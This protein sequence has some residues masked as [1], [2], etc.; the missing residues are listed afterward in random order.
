M[1]KSN[2]YLRFSDFYARLGRLRTRLVL[3]GDHETIRRITRHLLPRLPE[4]D[5]LYFTED[6]CFKWV[7]DNEH[8]IRYFI[9]QTDNANS[10][11]AQF[12]LLLAAAKQLHENNRVITMF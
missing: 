5:D 11:N 6:D 8:A 7:I 3:G 2:F 1:S 9:A 4:L 10:I 12:D